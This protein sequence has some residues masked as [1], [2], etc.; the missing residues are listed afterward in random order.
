MIKKGFYK[1]VYKYCENIKENCFK[2]IIK[3]CVSENINFFICE[4]L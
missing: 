3:M 4:S 1:Y 2:G